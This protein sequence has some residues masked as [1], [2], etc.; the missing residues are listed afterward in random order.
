MLLEHAA[1]P[2]CA[3]VGVPDEERGQL[4]KAFVVLR[5]GFTGDATLVKELQDFVKARIAPYKYPRAIEFVDRAP[6]HG[7]GQAATLPTAGDHVSTTTLLPPR[8]GCR[9]R[10]TRT[11]CRERTG[12]R[13][14]RA[15]RLE[16][17]DE[18]VRD[19]R[20]R[21]ADAAG[22][23]E[24]RGAA[25][26][27]AAAPKHVIR[28]TWFIVDRKAYT[29]KLAEVGRAYREV[30]GKHYPAMTLVVVAGLVEKRAQVEIEATAVV[31]TGLLGRSR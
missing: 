24:H 7:D 1:V 23:G 12:H 28:L 9:R 11:A 18:R 14:G 10:A 13:G 2:E 31:P 27:G 17:A 20:L 25:E 19:R 21:G 16:S 6:A 3:V 8:A 5:A 22:A 15:D 29:S 26:G 30:F 4:V